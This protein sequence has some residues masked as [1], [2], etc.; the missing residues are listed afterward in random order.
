MRRS[1]VC[2]DVIPFETDRHCATGPGMSLK[3]IFRRMKLYQEFDTYTTTR[4]SAHPLAVRGAKHSHEST[5]ALKTAHR[6]Q[7]SNHSPDDAINQVHLDVQS[8]SLSS[9]S[10]SRTHA[11]P[12]TP[13]WMIAANARGQ[14]HHLDATCYPVSG[15]IWM[16]SPDLL[17]VEFWM[18]VSINIV[19]HSSVKG[20]TRQREEWCMGAAGREKEK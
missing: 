12:M 3:F 2:L 15:W 13:K 9:L 7:I 16:N 10:L 11:V 4:T 17:F 20:K 1:H 5:S 18:P 19:V 6:K 8:R 14:Q